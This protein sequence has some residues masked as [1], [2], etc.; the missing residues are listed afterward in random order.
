MQEGQYPV[1]VQPDRNFRSDDIYD[2]G[3]HASA[4]GAIEYKSDVFDAAL[5]GKLLVIRYSAGK[6][7][8]VFDPSGTNGKILSS[9]LGVTGFTGFDDPLDL[10][11]DTGNGYLYVTELGGA[12][13][14][15]LRPMV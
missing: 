3:L 4:D 15:L 1:G 13:I 2:A 7:I 9:T 6:D 5:Q 8:M 11:E 10:T 14:T 12:K